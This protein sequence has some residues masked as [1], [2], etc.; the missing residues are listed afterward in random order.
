MKIT[1]ESNKLMSF[2]VENNCLLPLK[3]TKK[4]DSML[5][6]LYDEIKN[7]VSYINSVKAKM[8]NSFYKLN[9]KHITNVK[10]I[11]KQI[12]FFQH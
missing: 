10:Q 1:K 7:G 4:T 8:G 6:N 11:L 9:I 12:L 3:Q 2:F 5:K